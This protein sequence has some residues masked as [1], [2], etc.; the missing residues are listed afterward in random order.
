MTLGK[1]G[2]AAAPDYFFQPNDVLVAPNGDIFVGEGHGGGNSRMFKFDKT[3][4]LLKTWGKLGLRPGEFS[5]PH[6]L[7][8]D[9][10]GRLFV[11]DRSQQPRA[12]VRSGR[13]VPR[14]RRRRSAV[15]AASSSTRTTTSMSPTPSRSPAT[16]TRTGTIPA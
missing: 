13:Q 2:G 7:A 14:P 12:G 6:A 4:K 9:S 15:R 11:G 3:G 16:R 5:Q 1:P 8:M 10:Q